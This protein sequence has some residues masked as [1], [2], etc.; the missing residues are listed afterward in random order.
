MMG[1][2]DASGPAPA[3]GVA[4]AMRHLKEKLDELGFDKTAVHLKET[5]I[6]RVAPT[7]TLCA[8]QLSNVF[9]AASSP[10]QANCQERLVYTM[11]Y[12]DGFNPCASILLRKWR[13][14]AE[15]DFR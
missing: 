7:R 8:M 1:V 2:G 11:N 13:K 6:L 4:V 15:A 5:Q 10:K 3:R 12:K 14:T 9:Y